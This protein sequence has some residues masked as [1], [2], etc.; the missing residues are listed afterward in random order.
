MTDLPFRFRFRV[1]YGECDAQSVVFNARYADYVDISVNEYI[2]TL[3]GDYQ[4]LL[5]QDLDIQV[6]SLTMH[7]RAPARFDD[8]LEA[9]IKA[10]RIGT[11]SFTLHLE[12]YR[13]GDGQLVAEADITYVLI[14]PSQMA[15]TALPAPIREKLE[16]GAPGVLVSHAGE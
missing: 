2:R 1:R 15:K 4:N 6:V 5:D 9:R 16:A 10:G 12:F 7:Y 13:Y 3:F 8:V 14:Q 11:T